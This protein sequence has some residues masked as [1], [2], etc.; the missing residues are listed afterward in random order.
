MTTL[1]FT[2]PIEYRSCSLTYDTPIKEYL[3]IR[4]WGKAGNIRDLNIKWY[5]PGEKE[6]ACVQSLLNHYLVPELERLNAY[7]SGSVVLTRHELRRTF[8]IILASLGCHTVLPLWKE[9]A[10]NLIDSVIEPWAFELIVGSQLSVTMPDGSNVRKTVA[11]VIHKVQK[12]ILEID[13]SDT[14]SI[15]SIIHVRIKY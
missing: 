11:D 13:E 14:K 6:V 1:T 9:P 5:M 4:D 3:S 15:Y 2:M 7:A 10:M 12:K 8:K